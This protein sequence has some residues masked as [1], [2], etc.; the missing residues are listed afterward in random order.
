MQVHLGQSSK[1]RK[2]FHEQDPLA[3]KPIEVSVPEL[4]RFA[5]PIFAGPMCGVGRAQIKILQDGACERK[6]VLPLSSDL[7]RARFYRQEL[8][9]VQAVRRQDLIR[10]N[11]EAPKEVQRCQAAGPFQ[12]AVL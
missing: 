3:L 1:K 7:E 9:A 2:M 8:R 6:C 12:R 10:A 11:D 4:G 5:D